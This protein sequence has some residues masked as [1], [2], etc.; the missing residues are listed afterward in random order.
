MT[1]LPAVVLGHWDRMT[2]K[3]EAGSTDSGTILPEPAETLR[4]PFDVTSVTA[5]RGAVTRALVDRG[6]ERQTIDD[7]NIVVGELVMNAIR[8]GRPHRDDTIEV[9]WSLARDTLQFSVCDGGQVE[10]LEAQ[11]PA[12]T[13]FGGRGLGM[14]EMLCRRWEYDNRDGT[15]VTAAIPAA[16]AS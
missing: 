3:H 11:M 13:E 1:G 16:L 6:A 9:A 12:P 14:V 10:H 8:H 15:R 7:A 4:L 2:G 5:A